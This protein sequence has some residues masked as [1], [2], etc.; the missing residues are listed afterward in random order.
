MELIFIFQA[1]KEHIQSISGSL[2]QQ[3][4]WRNIKITNKI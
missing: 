4:F 2:Y 3:I 1:F